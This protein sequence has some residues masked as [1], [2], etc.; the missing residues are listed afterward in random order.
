MSEKTTKRSDPFCPDTP[1]GERCRV[2]GAAYICR[3]W[4]LP[5]A[6]PLIWNESRPNQQSEPRKET[7]A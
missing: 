7:R 3:R 5:K 6:L 2:C 4:D 1:K